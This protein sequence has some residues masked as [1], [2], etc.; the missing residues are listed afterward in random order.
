V[1][2]S[3]TM[4][5]GLQSLLFYGALSWL[6]SIHRDQGID[7]THAGLLLSSMNL[8]S[9][10]G[11]FLAPVIAHRMADQR[12]AAA[13]AAVLTVGGQLGV[14]LGPSSIALVWVILLG[15]G[16]GSALSLSLLMMV[17]RAG[18]DDT[19][20]RLS[21]MAQG[22]GY[23]LAAGGPL[24]LGLLHASTGGWDVPLLALIAI[25]LVEAA[26]GWSAGRDRTVNA[27]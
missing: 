25:G 20:A 7:P 11:T 13:G 9:I 10:A 16:Q 19:A 3:V 26:F 8:V 2:W 23:L 18:D 4:F 27:G 21:S 24:L 1:A 15:I 6:P 17:L 14:L 12:L 5:M 22:I